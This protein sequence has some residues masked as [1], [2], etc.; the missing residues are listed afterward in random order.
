VTRKHLP[1]L[2]RLSHSKIAAQH[3]PVLVR[4]LGAGIRV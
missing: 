4:R 2:A 3:V 1:A